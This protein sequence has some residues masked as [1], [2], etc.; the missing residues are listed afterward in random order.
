MDAREIAEKMAS[1]MVELAGL[2]MRA[3][4]GSEVAQRELR[5][6][7]NR[8]P[9]DGLVAKWRVEDLFVAIE[10]EEQAIDYAERMIE[11]A[12]ASLQEYVCLDPSNG[13]ELARYHAS[14]G[15]EAA[16]HFAALMD[17]RQSW[18]IALASKP[19]Q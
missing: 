8:L 18:E 9:H 2:L 12:S 16:R 4:C 11:Q 5:C 17:A 7:C 13:K 6:R 3:A 14:N 19:A 15:R 1:E 10:K